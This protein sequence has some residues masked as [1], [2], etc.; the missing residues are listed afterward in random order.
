MNE[1]EAKIRSFVEELLE[2]KDIA[3]LDVLFTLAF[4]DYHAIEKNQLLIKSSVGKI[5]EHNLE[6]K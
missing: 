2:N 1:K 6:V 4:G 5:A 3:S